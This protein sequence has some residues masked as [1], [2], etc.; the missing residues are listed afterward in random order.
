MRRTVESAM[1]FKYASEAHVLLSSN[2]LLR[3]YDGHKRQE[4]TS[5]DAMTPDVAVRVYAGLST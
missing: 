4:R 5:A 3:L 2:K 1:K